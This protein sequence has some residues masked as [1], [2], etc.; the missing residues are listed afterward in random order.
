MSVFELIAG[1]VVGRW[2]GALL[3][4][5]LLTAVAVGCSE[6]VISESAQ[7]PAPSGA[8]TTTPDPA[9]SPAPTVAASVSQP[10][11]AATVHRLPSGAFYLLAGPTLAS[12]NVWQVGPGGQEQQLT[13]NQRGYGIDAFAA[14][15]AGLILA[16]AAHGVDHLARWTRHGPAW[17]RMPGTAGSLIRGSSPD[18][19]DNGMIGY[20]TPPLPSGTGRSADFAIWI[21]SSFTGRGTI[22]HRQRQALA[23]PVFG[24]HDQIAVQGWDRRQPSV[25]IYRDG[26]FH[27]LRTGVQAIPSLLAWGQHAPALAIA[28]PS[29]D[30]ELLFLNGRRVPLPSGWQPLAWNP[31]GTKLLMQSATAL[32][33]WSA[34]APGQVTRIGGITPGVHILQA[35]WLARKVPL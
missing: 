13:A 33:I 17:L 8:V 20:V 16:E 14:S 10:L 28:F 4:V 34:A 7:S 21:R 12:L 26:G 29:H 6:G 35:T 27:Q 31:A 18:I 15:R 24:P 11:P 3:T 19:R 9:P 22:V 23:G 32:G 5:C 1:R 25:I 2:S 30:A